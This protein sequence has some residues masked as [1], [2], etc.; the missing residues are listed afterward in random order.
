MSAG[1]PKLPPG[2]I[3]ISA[4]ATRLS[5]SRQTLY[6]WHQRYGLPLTKV[7][8]GRAVCERQLQEWQAGFEQPKIGRPIKRQR[9]HWIR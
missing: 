2:Y 9:T 7:G 5:I 6:D 1:P 4:A 3:S 8:T